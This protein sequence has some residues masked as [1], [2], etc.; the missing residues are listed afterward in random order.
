MDENMRT[1]ERDGNVSQAS[2]EAA[3]AGVGGRVYLT[4]HVSAETAHIAEGYPFG[5]RGKCL[6]RT[7]VEEKRKHGFRIVHQTSRPYYPESGDAPPAVAATRWNK[8]KA[9][10]YCP[11]IVL[12]LDGATGHIE[13]DVLSGWNNLPDSE[14]RPEGDIDDFV[15][16]AKVAI[17][18]REESAVKVMRILRRASAR[19]KYTVTEDTRP[20]PRTPEES[21]ARQAEYDAKREEERKYTRALVQNEAA[22]INGKDVPFPTLDAATAPVQAPT[23]GVTS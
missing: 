23:G 21:A 20:L 2:T 12:Y 10:T 22:K 13:H 18:E 8:P 17:G 11:C 6:R 14:T 5:F 19:I 1:N 4:G 9:G 3:R 7:W 15:A 16:R